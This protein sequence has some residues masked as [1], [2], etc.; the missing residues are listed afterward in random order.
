MKVYRIMSGVFAFFVASAFLGMAHAATMNF[1]PAN[2]S[3]DEP[4]QG[5]Y[6]SR[7]KPGKF[8]AKDPNKEPGFWDKEFKRSGLQGTGKKLKGFV[9]GVFSSIGRNIKNPGDFFQKQEGKY[10]ARKRGET[11]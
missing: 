6:K 10:L 8:F 7:V 9:G 4:Y 2:M 3:G 1:S 11:L 5:E